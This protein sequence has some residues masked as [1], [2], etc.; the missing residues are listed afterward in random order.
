M[1]SNILALLSLCCLTGLL[2]ADE[3][4]TVSLRLDI[5]A[6]GDAI[7]G[8][9]VGTERE[10]KIIALPFT[11][12]QPLKY[13]GPALLRLHHDGS[14]APVAESATPTP[15]DES[16][17]SKPLQPEKP[18]ADSKELPIPAELAQ[19][20]EKDPTIAALVPL[21][22]NSRRVTILL[23]PAAGGTFQ[24]YVIDDDPSKL[25]P[26]KLRVHNLSPF[27]IAM[28]FS[29]GTKTEVKRGGTA[30]A[31]ARDGQAAYRLAYQKDEEWIIQ[32]NNVIPIRENE[33][34]QF[35]VLKSTN[36]FFLSKDGAA[37]GF[38]QTVL[39]RRPPETEG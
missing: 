33:Q 36:A 12:S 22:R 34:T 35:I 21:P 23:A 24:P 26:G 16:H 14:V 4:P 15:E 5:V 28:Q 9:S 29:D 11:Y 20:R 27:P 10:E 13:S 1:K 25:P 18:G 19:A 37:G 38:L 31:N 7:H 32:E 6:W 3:E 17:T 8:L 30:L 2:R 39:L